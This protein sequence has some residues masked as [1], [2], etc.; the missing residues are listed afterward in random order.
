MFD[1]GETLI[2]ETRTWEAMA[3]AAGVPRFT[4]MATVGGAHRGWSLAPRDFAVLGVPEPAACPPSEPEDLYPDARP[5]LSALQ[6]LG[7]RVGVAANQP[8]RAAEI[9]GS[10]GLD[11]DFVATSA[12]WGVA[13]PSPA[14][15]E[16]IA[17]GAGTAA[18]R[19]RICRRP[20]RQRHRA[21]GRRRD[22]RDL[23]APRAVGVD[24][25]SGREPGR[26][27][28]HGRK[29]GG[30]AGAPGAA[31]LDLRVR[32]VRCLMLY[33]RHGHDTTLRRRCHPRPVARG[34]RFDV[35]DG[36]AR[37]DGHGKARTDRVSVDHRVRRTQRRRADRRAVL[38]GRRRIL[39]A[40]ATTRDWT[41]STPTSVPVMPNGQPAVRVAFLPTSCARADF[42]VQ[43]GN[44]PPE[45][46]W[47]TSLSES[48]SG[49]GSAGSW[50]AAQVPRVRGR[51]RSDLSRARLSPARPRDHPPRRIAAEGHRLPVQGRARAGV[52]ERRRHPAVVDDDQCRRPG[53]AARAEE[54]AKGDTGGSRLDDIRAQRR[55]RTERRRTAG[56][57][58]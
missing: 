14:F 48:A 32:V 51:A 34:L 43:V 20:D 22:V 42:V 30:T 53:A 11:L 35:P 56:A 5:C 29:P 24:R 1:V 55:C 49:Q 41:G 58:G 3:D 15:F 26:R 10:I 2:D 54:G 19:H 27:D 6:E 47:E 16:R 25:V 36:V 57:S 33:R 31:D 8:D 52:Y 13:K 44:G 21:R 46:A 17:T 40:D 9:R 28:L 38:S 45:D 37:C 23:P 39:A 12:A 4:F 7:L 50:P 18:R